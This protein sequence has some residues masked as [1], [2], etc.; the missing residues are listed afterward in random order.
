MP[1]RP[2]MLGCA[3]A[4]ATFIAGFGVGRFTADPR[5]LDPASDSRHAVATPTGAA[6]PDGAETV[7]EDALA[8]SWLALLRLAAEVDSLESLVETLREQKLDPERVVQSGLDHMSDRELESIVT[9][10]VHLSAEELGE[11][12]DLR[13]FAAR[14]AEVAMEGVLE[15]GGERGPGDRVLLTT[16]PDTEDPEAV[17]SDRFDPDQSRIYAV[18]PTDHYEEAAVMVK[19]YRRDTPRILLFERYPITPGD[20]YAYVWLQPK[21]GWDPG[22]YQVDV[23]AIDEAVTLLSR[24]R[25]TV[26]RAD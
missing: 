23:Y 20:A 5:A 14:L 21:Q 10:A 11:V 7:P 1:D 3:A 26:A 18:F 2:W 9:S 24:G 13:A 19:W 16:S 25:Y 15:P 22:D 4:L 8:D 12:R 6:S 17:A